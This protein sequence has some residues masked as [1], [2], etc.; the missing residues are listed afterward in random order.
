MVIEQKVQQEESQ[1]GVSGF[2]CSPQLADNIIGYTPVQV[3]RVAD[4]AE[5]RSEGI[6]AL[7][8]SSL[9]LRLGLVGKRLDPVLHN[10]QFVSQ[11]LLQLRQHVQSVS[12]RP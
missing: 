5:M 6:W 11:L 8:D 9:G 4:R 3:K 12:V 1:T 7:G 2:L 10:L